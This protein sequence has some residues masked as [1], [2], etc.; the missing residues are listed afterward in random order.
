M[1]LCARQ[2][3]LSWSSVD[4]VVGGGL[5]AAASILAL[6]G[7]LV[8]TQD[9]IANS[10]LATF[11]PPGSIAAGA[12]HPLGTDQIGR[13][14]LARIIEGMRISLA[15]VLVSGAIGSAVGTAAGVVAGYAGG[16]VDAV[17]MRLVDIQLAIPFILL[18]LLIMAVLGP[19][20]LNLVVVLGLTSW[21]IYA[22]TA[23]ARVLE[24]RELE[25]VEGARAI[26][27]GLPRV[28]TRHV[29]PNIMGP[30]LVLLTLDLPR[31]VV[32]EASVGFLGLGV[33]PPTPTLGN[34]LGDGRSF[35]L[36]A[37]WL[38][39]YPGL[40]ISALVVG[41]NLV[42]DWLVWRRDRREH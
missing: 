12:W 31:L 7:K 33:Q 38:V 16:V 25:Y 17:L 9:P 5:L 32:L 42:G 41:F 37:Q 15:I 29:L 10:L 3:R 1:S 19:S 11:R 18:I 22:R 40:A 20:T 34:L 35:L 23:R 39:V 24:V 28:L 21:P 27:A 26:G 6:A 8:W 13:D 30:Q 36:N 14:L 2:R 4:L